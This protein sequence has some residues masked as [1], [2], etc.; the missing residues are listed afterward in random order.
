V[1]KGLF[2]ISLL[3]LCSADACKPGQQ[4]H[5][6]CRNRAQKRLNCIQALLDKL[7]R[8]KQKI[9]E[10]VAVP[11]LLAQD[12]MGQ[13]PGIDPACVRPEG[14]L[15]T[16]I[17]PEYSEVNFFQAEPVP[18]DAFPGYEGLELAELQVCCSRN[19]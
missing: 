2:F 1:H 8:D 16:R 18:V 14:A 6:T 13:R 15:S 19:T 17:P 5:Q 7:D 10:E 9:R 11:K 12:K 4:Q 3:H